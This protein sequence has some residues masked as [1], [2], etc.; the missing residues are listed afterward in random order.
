MYAHAVT[1]PSLRTRRPG[2]LRTRRRA[3]FFG[4]NTQHMRAL[5]R[6]KAAS[7]SWGREMLRATVALANVAGW[8]ALIYFVV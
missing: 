3:P 1:Y 7:V 6:R 8:G 5:A 4:R 2:R